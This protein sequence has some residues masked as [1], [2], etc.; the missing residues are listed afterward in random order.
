MKRKT[1]YFCMLFCVAGLL[2]SCSSV[3]TRH[4][5]GKTSA[6]ESVPGCTPSQV[7]PASLPFPTR[8]NS[9]GM[10]FVEIPA[11]TFLMGSH[12]TEK[13]RHDEIPKHCVT[14]SRPFSL[15]KYEVTQ[16][17]WAAVMGDNPSVYKNP[18]HPVENV[19]WEEVQA[20]I[21]R[22]N[23][24]ENTH[25]YRLPTEAEWEYAARAGTTTLFSFGEKREATHHVCLWHLNQVYGTCPVGEKKPNPWGLYDVH[26]NIW[27]WVEDWYDPRYYET[28]PRNDPRGPA[29]G[30][31]RV[32][33]GGGWH[34]MLSPIRSAN[35][36]N[37]PPAY[38]D[39]R[40][41]FRLAFTIQ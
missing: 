2:V 7:A 1:G 39:A 4:D 12:K 33:R 38:R 15:G 16:E 37:R 31:L 6:A 36:G 8:K 14:I 23:K 13:S 21:E 40:S 32:L 22:L 29:T 18:G 9:I 25:K 19:S 10:E 30:T 20:F 41:G 27:E 3:G 35:R 5:S 17:Q 34:S 28:S 24:K 11:G 26:G